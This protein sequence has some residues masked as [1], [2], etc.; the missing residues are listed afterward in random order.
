MTTRADDVSTPQTNVAAPSQDADVRVVHA[1][2]PAP[3][4]STPGGE[5]TA[6]A[7]P[8]PATAPV[9]WLPVAEAAERTSVSES[10]LRKWI[11]AGELTTRDAPGPRGLRTEVTVEAVVA[12]ARLAGIDASPRAGLDLADAFARLE[13]LT[14]QLIAMSDR[15]ARA[16]VERDHLKRRLDEVKAENSTALAGERRRTETERAR[17]DDL[18][19]QLSASREALTAERARA[20]A[21]LAA[22]PRRKRHLFER[23]ASGIP[24]DRTVPT[25]GSGTPAP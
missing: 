1:V 24:G 4:G 19:V 8:A 15:A 20:D 21:M 16:E 23:P 18:V 11:K 25:Q 13:N 9:T 10:A 5:S 14:G 7:P 3:A 6:E 2:G 12:R 22:V 17:G